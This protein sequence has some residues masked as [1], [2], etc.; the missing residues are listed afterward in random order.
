MKTN[1]IWMSFFGVALATSMTVIGCGSSS[2]GGTFAGGGGTGGTGGSG[3]SGGGSGTGTASVG[4]N[5]GSVT[6]SG[7][8]NTTGS[9]TGGTTTNTTGTTTTTDGGSG[10][11]TS[12]GGT[13]TGGFL[14]SAPRTAQVTSLNNPTQMSRL[15]NQ[16]Y[17]LD[18]FDFGAN[19]GRLLSTQVTSTGLNFPVQ[20]RPAQGSPVQSF[21]NPWGIVNDGTNL[22]ISVGFGANQEGAILRVSNIVFSGTN[23]VTATATFTNIT[24]QAGPI[25]NPTFMTTAIVGGNQY[26]YWSEYSA[27]G[28][29][30]RVRRVLL[31]DQVNN[32]VEIVVAALN[33]PA[34]LANDQNFLVVCDS[35]GG[36][37]SLGQVVRVPLT[38]TGLPFTPGTGQARTVAVAAGQQNVARPFDVTYDGVNGFF[39]TEGSAISFLSDTTLPVPS[40]QGNGAVRYLPSTTSNTGTPTASLVANGLTNVAGINTAN[41][42]DG[43]VGVLV[44]ENVATNGRVLRFVANPASP[45]LT[46]PSQVDTGLTNPLDVLIYDSGLPRFLATIST[47]GQANGLLNGYEGQ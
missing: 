27:I 34:G 5:G 13:G 18:G 22:Y 7:G 17:F 35:A 2:D 28:T 11:T 25:S 12:T 24:T 32:P 41:L 14:G 26:L 46:T 29:T 8:L 19:Q 42:T 9:G 39:F 33:Y 1:K 45:A 21:S 30:G 23:P 40:G 3:A 44:A 6:G 38:N 20:I 47:P 37:G 10:T 31:N 4:L 36:E 16:V 15:G 43:N